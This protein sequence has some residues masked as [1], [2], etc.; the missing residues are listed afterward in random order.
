MAPSRMVM[1]YARQSRCSLAV[2]AFTGA[3]LVSYP[4]GHRVLAR[5]RDAFDGLQMVVRE[6]IKDRLV[7]GLIDRVQQ[8]NTTI[9]KLNAKLADKEV[10]LSE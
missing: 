5:D 7:K 8:Q 10:E 1:A 6:K 4:F 9:V 2:R 3:G